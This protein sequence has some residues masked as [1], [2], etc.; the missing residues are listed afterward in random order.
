MTNGSMTTDRR[1][2]GGDPKK[3]RGIRIGLLL[4]GVPQ[5]A[6]GVWALVSPRG[7]FDG[8]PGAGNHWIPAYGP[9][10]EHLVVD[11]GS[12]FLALGL[13]LVIAAVWLDRRAV[14]LSLVAYLAYALPHTAYHLGADDVLSTGDEVF[15]G[16]ALGLAVVTAAALLVV[17]RAPKPSGRKP[18]RLAVDGDGDTGSRLRSTV[19]GPFARLTRWYGRRRYGGELAPVDAYLHT[20]GLLMGYGALETA[21][22]RASRVDERL[23]ALAETKAAAIVGCEWCMDFATRYSLDHGVDEAQLRELP[24]HRDSDAFTELEKLVL[25]YADAM[26]RTP[27]VVSDQLAARMREHFDDAQLVELTNAI[28]IENLRARFNHALGLDPQGFSEGSYCVVPEPAGRE[29]VTA[30]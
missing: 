25:D 14:Q 4:L 20:R 24:R 19:G 7:W 1:V 6:I 10:D 17:S 16:V 8:F 28:A 15:N 9:F 30:P 11:V 29:A 12:T 18:V 13:A 2:G 27:A 5:A 26:S 21:T 3:A 23:K 22:E